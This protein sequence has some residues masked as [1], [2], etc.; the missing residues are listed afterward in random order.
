MKRLCLIVILLC[1]SFGSALSFTVRA[2][3]YNALAAQTDSTPFITATG[4]RARTGIVALSR[5]LLRL[6]PYGS[7][8]RLVAVQGPKCGGWTTGNLRVE[9][10][11]AAR[12]VRQAD[13]F[14]PSRSQSITWGVCTATLQVIQLARRR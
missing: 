9:D 10:T 13:V 11:M 4:T 8:V 12:K 3:S 14:L 1:S 5:D 7:V 6:V 2:T